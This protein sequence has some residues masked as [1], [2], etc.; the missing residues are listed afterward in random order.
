MI[1]SKWYD[2][3]RAIIDRVMATVPAGTDPAECRRICNAA[4]PGGPRENHPYKMWLR[5]LRDAMRERFPGHGEDGEDGEDREQAGCPGCNGSGC[6]FCK[7]KD[8]DS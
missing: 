3:C 4:W 5:A 1:S 7:G 6:L 8:G 2:S